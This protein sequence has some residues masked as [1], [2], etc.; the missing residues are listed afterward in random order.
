MKLQGCFLLILII[1]LF[2]CRSKNASRFLYQSEQLII[3]QLSEQVYLHTSFLDIPNY[4]KFPCNG[5]IY[6]GEKEAIVFDTPV[7]SQSTM[8]LLNFLEKKK[9]DVKAVVINH[10][11]NDCLGGLDEFHQRD[12]HSYASEKTI[13]LA[14]EHKMSIPQHGFKDSLIL[15]LDSQVVLNKYFGA[16]HTA[17]NI[18]SYIPSENLLFGGCLIKALNAG[19]GNLAD[20]DLSEW[21]NT[22]EKV[23]TAYPNLKIVVP[24]HEKTGGTKLL[25]YTIE[26][27]KV[28]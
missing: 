5:I 3:E 8:E 24:G 21:S 16:G 14:Q 2:S 12:I 23:K 26:M 22:V 15:Y 6:H 17:D 11:H 4:G 1:Q 27:F 25:D 7:D 13:Q 28:R 20:A 18:V 10:F 9:W 19:K